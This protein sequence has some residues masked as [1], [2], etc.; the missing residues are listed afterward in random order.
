Q[1][2][3][4]PQLQFGVI[5]NSGLRA[6]WRQVGRRERAGAINKD[7]QPPGDVHQLVDRDRRRG[8]AWVPSAKHLDHR[9]RRNP[10]GPLLVGEDSNPSGKLG[11]D[12]RTGG[13]SE[14]DKINRSHFELV[15][16][17][18][19]QASGSGPRRFE[20]ANPHP[21][22]MKGRKQGGGPCVQTWFSSGA[23]LTAYCDG[24]AAGI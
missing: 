17:E 5:G 20:I 3:V 7:A 22:V 16:G 10:G 18:L 9:R 1:G 23:R 19:E 15:E 24:T 11:A 8:P 13:V 6:R 2:V 4:S 14:K 21:H 12:Q